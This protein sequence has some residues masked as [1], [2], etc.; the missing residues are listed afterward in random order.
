[1]P[2]EKVA[3]QVAAHDAANRVR[4]NAIVVAHEEAELQERI[5]KSLKPAPEAAR[6]SAPVM[7]TPAVA[8]GLS[9]TIKV[10]AEPT[11]R[12][13]TLTDQSNPPQPAT[14]PDGT[15]IPPLSR[16]DKIE[17]A[18]RNLVNKLDEMATSPE[19]KG[20]FKTALAHGVVYTGPVWTPE[21]DWA[22]TLLK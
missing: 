10:I 22:R 14:M 12:N 16:E 13:I 19:L 15:I 3:L 17:M 2:G 4:D 5:A 20:V 7:A 6:V 11:S 21:V 8:Q 9:E 1:M 18:L